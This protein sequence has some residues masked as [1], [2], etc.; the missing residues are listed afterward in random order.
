MRK[1]AIIGASYLQVPLIVKAKSMGIETH[2][3]AWQCGD[4]GEKIGDNFYPIS[5]IE[6]KQILEKC[7]D[8]KIDGICSIASDLASITVNY[9]AWKLGL[10]GNT[11]KT[12]IQSTNKFEMKKCFTANGIPSAE[13]CLFDMN[14]PMEELQLQFPVIVKPTDRSGSRGVTK[15]KSFQELK[16]AIVSAKVQSFEKRVLIERFIDGSEFSV[17]FISF[18]RCHFFLALTQKFTTGEP[19]FI[20]TGHIEPAII[21]EKK[22]KEIKEI[23]CSVLD[24]IGFENGASHTELKIDRD[25]NIFIIEV[26][27]RMGGDLI[28]SSLVPIST[29]IDFVKAVIKIAFGEIP[30]LA[31]KQRPKTA[32]IRFILNK[33]DIDVFELIKKEHPEYLV[34]YITDSVSDSPILDSSSRRGYFLM[35]ADTVEEIQRYLPDNT[36]K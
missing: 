25:G 31:T 1:L 36:K 7:K 20:E 19:H 11:L 23:V 8:I 27:G 21:D 18:H 26:G 35:Q 28:G 9:V 3:F 24:S 32:A 10:A 34:E 30:D 2:V 16:E 14:K 13:F 15:V 29:G 33:R 17:E 22:M 6:K 5:I 4:I 12:T